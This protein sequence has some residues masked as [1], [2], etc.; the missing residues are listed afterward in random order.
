MHIWSFSVKPSA[1]NLCPAIFLLLFSELPA[2][3]RLVARQ[4]NKISHQEIFPLSVS[5][6]D[7]HEHGFVL[8]THLAISEIREN[9]PEA[10]L[11]ISE[12]RDF[13]NPLRRHSIPVLKHLDGIYRDPQLGEAA[14]SAT[15]K[16]EKEV[17]YREFPEEVPLKVPINDPGLKSGHVYYYRFHYRGISSRIGRARTLPGRHQKLTQLKL[18]VVSCQDYTSGLYEAFSFLA[19]ESIDYVLHLGDVIY[20]YD[21]YPGLRKK[22]HIRP[23]H[24]PHGVDSL[25]PEAGVKKANT[26]SDFRHIYRL[27]KK[28]PHFQKALENHSWIFTRD[29]HEFADNIS[30]NN[31]MQA[32][33]FP[34]HDPRGAWSARAKRQVVLNALQAW[35]EFI[36]MNSCFRAGEK[37]PRQM[38]GSCFKSYAFGHLAEL[39]VLVGRLF[40]DRSDPDPAKHTML[41]LEQ[42]KWLFEGVRNSRAAWQLLGNQTLMA[43]FRLNGKAG[44]IAGRFVDLPEDGSV[45]LDAWDGFYKERRELL[46]TL[47]ERRQVAVFTGDMHTSLAS[48]LKRDF[49]KNHNNYYENIVGAEFMTPSVTSPNFS[50]II[51]A[52]TTV[53]GLTTLAS[54]ALT[55]LA[56]KI[57]EKNN[58]HIRHFHGGI[59]GYA[60]ASLT[61]ER[62][63][64]YVYKI[65]KKEGAECKLRKHLWYLPVYRYLGK[66]TR[67]AIKNRKP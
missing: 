33:D 24:L 48:Y 9:T 45:N 55:A 62:L 18:A 34:P 53:S 22:D 56:R 54:G 11:E 51:R 36:P 47:A 65:S 10:Y 1:V 16:E 7:P 15:C 20:E 59:H 67:K 44:K 39:F 3:S 23:I 52:S 49:S 29:D 5:S 40:R 35:N 19:R 17:F 30:W 21:R 41:G 42:K 31:R 66:D 12:N 27:E 2:D 8:M 4:W 25:A 13:S 43:P 64:W 61:Q 14:F 63:D 46:K 38:L 26:L 28:D 37:D 50:D 57:F 32:P 6:G 58:P 60:I